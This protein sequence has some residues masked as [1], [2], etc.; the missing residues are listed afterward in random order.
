[1]NRH[2]PM[3]RWSPMPQA[4][5][6][7]TATIGSWLL[8]PLL[9]SCGTS[10]QD[11]IEVCTLDL[12][13]TPASAAPGEVVTATGGPLTES[14]ARDHVVLVGGVQAD[15]LSVNR[16]DA[17]NNPLD[18]CDVCRAEARC[19]PCGF[20]PLDILA[21]Q[22]MGEA[23]LDQCFGDPLAEIEGLCDL[24][25]ETLT[26]VVPAGLPAGPTPVVV[27]NANGQSPSLVFD[28]AA[29]PTTG[30]GTGATT[31]PATTP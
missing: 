31:T 12:V 26:F 28:V 8:V 16:S 22:A 11:Q 9:V 4:G 30:T 20:C 1:M 2:R 10:F 27:F 7:R 6:P 29:A 25:E 15:V 17:C 23:R 18:G 14:G 21:A 19:P 24:C 13:L 5:R 3:G